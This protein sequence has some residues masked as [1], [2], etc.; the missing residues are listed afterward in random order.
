MSNKTTDIGTQRID[1]E[2]ACQEQA[3]GTPKKPLMGKKKYHNL[4]GQL[5]ER[6]RLR[7]AFGRVKLKRGAPGSDGVI[8][9]EFEKKLEEN[10]T[11]LIGELR[12]K[13]Y[14]PRPIRRVEIPK[15]N[16]GKRKLGI[17]SVRDRVVQDCLRDILEKV[18]E[19]FFSRK[20]KG[21]GLVLAI[22][23]QIIESHKGDIR[24]ESRP[25]RGTAFRIRLPLDGNGAT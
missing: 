22:V 4:Y 19:P 8:I 3:T 20:K 21:T 13:E 2:A 12:R 25:G 15:R 23:H 9:E 16:G 1:R 5:L 18:F 17:P 7:A 6:P 24:V 14:R 11:E 10:L